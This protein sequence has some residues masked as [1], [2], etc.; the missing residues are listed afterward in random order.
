M[1]ATVPRSSW[2]SVTVSDTAQ[3]F[4]ATQSDRGAARIVRIA[5][6]A[7]EPRRGSWIFAGEPERALQATAANEQ[8]AEGRSVFDEIL[9]LREVPGEGG[10]VLRLP[11]ARAEE[12]ARAL[13]GALLRHAL[14]PPPEA[15]SGHEP[16]GRRLERPHVA[17]LA[18]P[19]LGAERSSVAGAAIA[20]PHDIGLEE[21]QAVLLAA[22]RW[23]RSGLRLLLGR[24]GAM[25][26]ARVVQPTGTGGFDPA[27]WT[28]PSRRWATVTPVAL[29]HNPGNLRAR[30]PA[31][32]ARAARRAEEIVSRGCAH[33]CLPRP[34]RV[35]IM[36]RS[37]FAGIPPASAFA[38]YP[39]RGSGFRRVC[40]HAELEFAEPV[41]GPV[42]LGAGRYFGVGLLR[43]LAG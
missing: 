20:F 9:L 10:R 13:R 42:L 18:L 24:L 19:E 4:S 2:A 28:G 6:R 26:L 39:R 8:P 15:L 25:K 5:R 41:E 21:R 3:C 29:Q 37:R 40:V 17:F 1:A 11:L 14:D 32:A 30:D 31:A 36:P 12:V 16:D 43:P 23:E 22:A 38:P 33:I 34:A 7:R 27:T 35:R